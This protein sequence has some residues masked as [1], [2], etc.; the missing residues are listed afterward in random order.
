MS[1]TYPWRKGCTQSKE[2][3]FHYCTD[4]TSHIENCHRTVLRIDNKEVLYCC[5]HECAADGCLHKA[6]VGTGLFCHDHTFTSRSCNMQ[7]SRSSSRFCAG[8]KCRFDLCRRQAVGWDSYCQSHTC[9]DPDCKEPV[10]S[11][12][13][14]GGRCMKY[15][16]RTVRHVQDRLYV[17]QEAERLLRKQRDEVEIRDR[18]TRGRKQFKD[19]EMW[20]REEI[21]I[22]VRRN[23]ILEKELQEREMRY[24]EIA[25][26]EEVAM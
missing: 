3:G 23:E 7:R 12:W 19:R 9:A 13:A 18:A 8:H 2:D 10:K 11:G 17:E 22:A 20:K 5:S 1:L 6:N 21:E 26:E 24:R 16:P 14:S 4:H 15:G 25:L